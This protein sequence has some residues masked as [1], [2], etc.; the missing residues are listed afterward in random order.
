M[1]LIIKN[2]EEGYGYSATMLPD[3]DAEPRTAYHC[4]YP[5]PGV[6]RADLRSAGCV[7]SFNGGQPGAAGCHA[8]SATG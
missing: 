7:R 3:Y 5:K 6:Y 4:P 2:K 1:K 8:G